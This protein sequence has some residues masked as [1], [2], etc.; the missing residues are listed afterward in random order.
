[1]ETKDCPMTED[2]YAEEDLGMFS[3]ALKAQLSRMDR[4]CADMALGASLYEGYV[5]EGDLFS[6]I[7]MG[8]LIGLKAE[9]LERRISDLTDVFSQD[10][11]WALDRMERKLRLCSLQVAEA[12]QDELDSDE[13]SQR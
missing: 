12:A 1:M 10:K 6:V 9:E 13:V 5:A 3:T 11:S 4:D 8:H 7:N 2:F